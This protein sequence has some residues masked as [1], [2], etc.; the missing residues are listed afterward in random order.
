MTER[1]NGPALLL[2][3]IAALSATS[4]ARAEP[5]TAGRLLNAA[6]EPQ[7][8][9]LPHA[10]YDAQRYSRL[11]L[12]N[13]SN[14]S[15]LRVV[16]SLPLGG[17]LQG[18]GNYV[19]ALPV[20]P[21]AADGF[22]YL[23][24]GSGKVLKVDAR[25]GAGEHIVWETDAGQNNLDAWLQ[26]R[27]GLALF[28]DQV[29][30]ISADG[31]LHWIDASSGELV[32]SVQVADPATGYSIAAPPLVI[33]DQIIVGGNGVD[34]GARGQLDAI[35]VRTGAPVWRVYAVPGPGEPGAE[36]WADAG[37]AWLHGG[38]G[39]SQTGAYDA[40]SGLTVWSA[41]SPFP[42]D[43]ARFRPGD[44]AF[45][46]SA[47][48]VDVATGERRWSF[49][50]TPGPFEGFSEAGPVQIVPT[51]GGTGVTHFGR[52]GFYYVLDLAT[53][54]F[55]SAT[56]YVP[57]STW[58]A[59]VDPAS[60]RPVAA[61]G[62]PAATPQGC[63]NIRSVSEFASSYSP[64][65]GLSYGAGAEGCDLA[66]QPARTMSNSGWMG[67]FYTGAANAIGS[68]AATDPNSGALVA[69]RRLDFPL[70][71]GTLTTAGGL[72][73]TTT[74][75]GTLYALNDET[76]ETV[77]S[78]PFASLTA[79]PPIT[80]AVDGE[81]FIAV[82]VGGNS[83]VGSLSYKPREMTAVQPL[84]VLAILGLR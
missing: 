46:N 42:V 47:I 25:P 36:I 6:S 9:L 75:N 14:V 63:P 33:G 29:I 52:N 73:F 24:E 61:D 3:A 1:R 45:A 77:W 43:D 32:Q 53:G 40:A 59:G 8:W 22:L 27:R 60:G 74:A 79:S 58:M 34:R 69:E 76:L 82:L 19:A 68:L 2:G 16:Y 15:G 23:V 28:E 67:A 31:A 11:D 83:F 12:I 56:P 71:A 78:M 51:N 26:A 10:T 7:N 81:Q 13:R 72:V 50:Y 80:F 21:L 49:Q 4:L 38:G 18:G 55:R 20:N 5:V 48:A 39:F 84:F 70:H 54:S 66:F 30:S 57:G 41:G 17:A 37:D 64:R 62:T 44:G 65:T 35:D